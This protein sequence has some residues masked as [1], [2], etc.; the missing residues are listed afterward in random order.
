MGKNTSGGLGAAL[1]PQLPWELGWAGPSP[2]WLRMKTLVAP[3]AFQERAC[4]GNQK[5]SS[6]CSLEVSS[7]ALSVPTGTTSDVF[8]TGDL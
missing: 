3:P 5:P 1:L 6:H 7:P 8:Q 2:A 4:F